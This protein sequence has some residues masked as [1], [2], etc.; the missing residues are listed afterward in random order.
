MADIQLSE[1]LK[2][3]STA[4]SGCKELDAW[5][6]MVMNP[7]RKHIFANGTYYKEKIAETRNLVKCSLDYTTSYDDA[8]SLLPE[9]GWKYSFEI[10]N[11]GASLAIITTKQEYSCKAPSLPLGL[12]YLVVKI[13]AIEGYNKEKKKS[14][15]ESQFF[16]QKELIADRRKKRKETK[17]RTQTLHEARRERYRQLF[18]K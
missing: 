6:D 1:V 5:V 16:S 15:F 18:G 11:S 9:K 10:N 4:F 13:A 8:I 17:K 3:L 2:A 7:S 14:A 12:S